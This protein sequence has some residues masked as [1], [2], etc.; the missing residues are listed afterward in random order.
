MLLFF[1]FSPPSLLAAFPYK[2]NLLF[3]PPRVSL[4]TAYLCTLACKVQDVSPS[5]LSCPY[6]YHPGCSFSVLP[7]LDCLPYSSLEDAGFP[8]GLFQSKF[9]QV[10]HITLSLGSFSPPFT[11]YLTDL[12]QAVNCFCG[13][14]VTSPESEKRKRQVY[15]EDLCAGPA[16]CFDWSK[17]EFF[18]F[19][20]PPVP[21]CS[22]L[23]Q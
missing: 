20:L 4:N 15:P 8:F 6:S 14:L 5:F 3:K 19:S 12:I 13:C 9:M 16:I 7:S 23:F 17:T 22:L 1:P 21:F 2:T 11:S 18:S 10:S